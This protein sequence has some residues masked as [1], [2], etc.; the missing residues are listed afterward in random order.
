LL[1]ENVAGLMA[2]GDR[3]TA[4]CRSKGPTRHPHVKQQL[5]QPSLADQPTAI[6]GQDSIAAR[7]P[8]LIRI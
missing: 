5:T 3:A 4:L 2:A 1:L 8:H 7:L 6:R